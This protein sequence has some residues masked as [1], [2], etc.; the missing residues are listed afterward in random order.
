MR[1]VPPS[2]MRARGFTLVEAIVSTCISVLA[3]AAVA[4]MLLYGSRSTAI[5]GNYADMNRF[6][7][8]ALDQMTTDIRQANK[9]LSCTTNQLQLQA[10]DINTGVVASTLT[11]TYSPLA[12]TLVRSY[13]GV[14]NTLLTGIVA[15]SLQ[16]KRCISPAQ[17]HRRQRQQLFHRQ[18]RHLQSNP[19][20][21]GAA[22]AT[23]MQDVGQTET[24]QAAEVV[25]RKE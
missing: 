14:T 24:V 22:P 23:F 7:V 8:N 12:Q 20:C 25:I 18:P 4:S 13:E 17:S 10:V 15:N 21:P 6:D 3:F 19:A 16:F 2:K 5:V 11:Y 9:V 1:R